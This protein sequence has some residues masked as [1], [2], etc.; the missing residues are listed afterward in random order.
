MPA[1]QADTAGKPCGLDDTDQAATPK[2]GR[3]ILSETAPVK[4]VCGR[5][6]KD[7]GPTRQDTSIVILSQWSAMEDKL[8]SS[9]MDPCSGWNRCGPPSHTLPPS[10]PSLFVGRLLQS[11][12]S[13][14]TRTTALGMEVRAQFRCWRPGFF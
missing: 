2:E 10:L 11:T 8:D 6:G 9:Y 4:S 14:V 7:G 13:P 3:G 12:G 5:G 1:W